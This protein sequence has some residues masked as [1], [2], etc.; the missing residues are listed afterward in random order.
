MGLI[1]Y[2]TQINNNNETLMMVVFWGR[3]ISSGQVAGNAKP[4]LSV[5]HGTLLEQPVGESS[6]TRA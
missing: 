3:I 4:G 5:G 2:L 1:T 6:V